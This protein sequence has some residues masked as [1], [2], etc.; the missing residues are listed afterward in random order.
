MNKSD[1]ETGVEW[2]RKMEDRAAYV[3]LLVFTWM[4]S[5]DIESYQF[6]EDCVTV[7]YYDNCN[8]G[9]SFPLRYMWMNKQE[10]AEDL[11]NERRKSERNRTTE[12]IK[13]LEEKIR[14]LRNVSATLKDTEDELAKLK[15]HLDS[16][17]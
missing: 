9:V 11:E 3:T 7:K 15:A 6:D 17:G 12:Q 16:L 14:I 5:G 8:E 4:R 13:D 1:I 2:V 10:I